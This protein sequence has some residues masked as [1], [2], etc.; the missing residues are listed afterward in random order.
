[1]G[2]ARCSWPEI[3]LLARCLATQQPWAL[4]ETF[5][6]VAKATTMAR[7]VAL[8]LS[9]DAHAVP[10]PSECWWPGPASWLP[11]LQEARTGNLGIFGA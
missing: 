4:A 8:A 1:M 7:G 2:S 5:G 10:M 3:T 9:C 11:V 6:S